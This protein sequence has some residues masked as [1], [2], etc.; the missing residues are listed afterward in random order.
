MD[1]V[2]QKLN[3]KL[4]ALTAQTNTGRDNNTNTNKFQT[5]IISLTNVKFTKEHTKILSLGPNYERSFFK[6]FLIN[7][8]Q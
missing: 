2:Y 3:K 8:N 7:F 5:R 4:D 1:N 6:M